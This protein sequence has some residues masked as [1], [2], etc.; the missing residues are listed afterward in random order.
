MSNFSLIF[1]LC[2]SP[3]GITEESEGIKDVNATI[4]KD[5][6]FGSNEEMNN[7]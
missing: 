5:S 6:R 7:K 2:I 1:I 4:W 3:I